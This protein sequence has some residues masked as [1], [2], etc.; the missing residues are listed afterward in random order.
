MTEESTGASL[1][2]E[3]PWDSDFFGLPI[4]RVPLDR[5]SPTDV[6][7][8]I[9]AARRSG[10]ACLYLTCAA[11][12]VVGVTA[13]VRGGFR[14]VD[15]RV[16]LDRSMELSE[17]TV[18]TV[19]TAERGATFPPSTRR[20]QESDLP[21]LARL[22]R[23]AFQESRFFVDGRFPRSRVEDLYQRW[24]E[25]DYSSADGV[26]V[27]EDV[28]TSGGQTAGF[29]SGLFQGDTARVG[30]VAVAP[31]F[32]GQGIGS[33][34]V[35]G[36]LREFAGR[37][38]RRTVVVTQARNRAAIRLYEEAGFRAFAIEVTLHWWADENPV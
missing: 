30:L 12:E 10:V 35:S 29:A 22:A 34:I 4:G 3:L 28:E 26:V 9:G 15:V 14:V 24:L 13:A 17:K 2:Q 5:P 37:R 32:R 31:E 6:A 27:V 8:A 38:A 1:V 20:A 33:R 19:P 18:A 7:E 23:T 25:R 21:R 11:D 16:T 36:L